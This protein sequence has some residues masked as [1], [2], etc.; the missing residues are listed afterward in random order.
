MATMK[1]MYSVGILSCDTECSSWVSRYASGLMVLTRVCCYKSV[2]KLK[3][4][5]LICIT[6]TKTDQTRFS[7]LSMS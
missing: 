5:H 6:E 4:H 7:Y 1:P 2:K 3:L